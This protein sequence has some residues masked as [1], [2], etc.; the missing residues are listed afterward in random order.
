MIS[1]N[2]G[3]ANISIISYYLKMIFLPYQYLWYVQQQ[4]SQLRL[5]IFHTDYSVGISYREPVVR[6]AQGLPSTNHTCLYYLLPMKDYLH[7]PK[8]FVFDY[9][10]HIFTIQYEDNILQ[11]G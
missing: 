4:C 11:I 6:V 3:V 2:K 10:S 9:Q 8:S 1:H 5:L 7:S